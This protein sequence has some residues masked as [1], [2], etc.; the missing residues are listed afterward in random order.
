MRNITE[1][2]GFGGAVIVTLLTVVLM[3]LFTGALLSGCSG[4]ALDPFTGGVILFCAFVFLAIAVGVVA[5]LV[6]RWRELQGGEED[7]AKKY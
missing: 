5:A 7:E 6:Q 1:G 4:G 3:L 2:K